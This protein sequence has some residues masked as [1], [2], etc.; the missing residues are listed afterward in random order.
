M[1]VAIVTVISSHNKASHLWCVVDE[2]HGM[3]GMLRNDVN[4]T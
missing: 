2:M 1:S 4:M 3:H